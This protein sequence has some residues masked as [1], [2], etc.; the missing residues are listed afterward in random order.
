MTEIEQRRVKEKFDR[1]QS[2]KSLDEAFTKVLDPSEGAG[3]GLVIMLLMLQRIGLDKKSL[4]ISNAGNETVARVR[5]PLD[6]IH[7]QD[8]QLLSRTIVANIE[9]LP[10]LPENIIRLEKSLNDSEVKMS[11]ITMQISQ[12]PGLTAEVL[13]TVNSA[14][15]ML[16]NK[17]ISLGDAVKLIGIRDLKNLLFSFSSIK[18]LGSETVEKRR[19][20]IHSY[21]TALIAGRLAFSYRSL[22]IDPSLAGNRVAS[23]IAA[24]YFANDCYV[25]G[26]LHDMGKIVFSNVHPAL[27][28]KIEKF[29]REKGISTRLIEELAAGLNHAEI[30]AMTAEKWQYPSNL[31]AAVRYHHDPLKAPAEFFPLVRNTYM[32][33]MLCNYE[34]GLVKYEQF[35]PQILKDYGIKSAE[36]LDKLVTLVHDASNDETL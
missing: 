17:V 27:L 6:K 24:R 26:I 10:Q 14:L 36:A 1:A 11:D 19:L 7:F 3:L 9:S 34:D 30:G 4:S 32:A 22:T 12:D 23:G 35:I 13:K 29:C 28:R 2:F 8:I 31:V 15:Y 16:H 18:L 20:W 33:N 5:L 25:A 21:K